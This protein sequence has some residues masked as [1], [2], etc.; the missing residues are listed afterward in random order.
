VP[1]DA[2]DP[3]GFMV[4]TASGN[5][6]FLTDLGHATKL[7]LER[8]RAANVLLLESNHDVEM[9]QNDPRRPWSLKQRILG[10]HGHLS[11]DSAADV[12][13]EVLSERLR[14][15]F[16]VHLSRECN[17]PEL[18]LKAVAGR[19]LKMGGTHVTV[20]TTSQSTPNPTFTF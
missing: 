4:R 19:L 9:L 11:N 12:A 18:A 10:R 5:L 16:L 2:S 15:L 7:V 14:R 20:E 6:G 17:R 1:H 3:V 8:I 13:G